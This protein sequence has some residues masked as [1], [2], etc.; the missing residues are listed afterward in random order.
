VITALNK[1]D[2]VDME[3]PDAVARLQ[4]ALADY[5]HAVAISALTGQG[6]DDL[7]TKIDDVLRSHM[8]P[9]DV[10]IPYAHGELVALVHEHGF[11]EKEEHAENG[12]HLVGR[13]P[14]ALA[15]RYTNYWYKD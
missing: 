5:P 14:V 7:R 1:V 15:G 8:A 10:L 9:I 2:Q 12:T 6:L 11:I 13:L 3:N 4:Q